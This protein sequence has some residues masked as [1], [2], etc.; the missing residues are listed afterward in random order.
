MV[1]ITLGDFTR[2]FTAAPGYFE[3]APDRS[4]PIRLVPEIHRSALSKWLRTVGVDPLS[5]RQ[6]LD[7]ACRAHQAATRQRRRG[8]QPARAVPEVLSN[9]DESLLEAFAHE[10]PPAAGL[11][12]GARDP[13]L[14]FGPQ[15][16]LCRPIGRTARKDVRSAATLANDRLKELAAQ[17]GLHVIDSDPV[18]RRH[19]AAG[20]GPVDRS[21]IDAHWNPAAHR[22][23]AQEVRVVDRSIP[24]QFLIL[25]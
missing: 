9:E 8:R 22:L 25:C 13:G 20:L 4:P 11:A 7:A 19:F 1:V 5:A 6:S 17:S 15:G 21:P 12:A 10:L 16:H 23:M 18:F 24:A 3:W 14:R 2:G